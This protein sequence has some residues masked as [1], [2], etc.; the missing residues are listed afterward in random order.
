MNLEKI[1]KKASLSLYPTP[2]ELNSHEIDKILLWRTRYFLRKGN[3][4]IFSKIEIETTTECNRACSYCPN[5]EYKREKRLMPEELF[6]KIIFDLEVMDYVGVVAPHL[7]GEPLLDTRLPELISFTRQKLPRARIWIYSNGDYLNEEVYSRLRESG[8]NLF[9]VT[10]HEG[11]KPEKFLEWFEKSVKGERKGIVYRRLGIKANRGNASAGEY[12]KMQR[13]II[14]SNNVAVNVEG[15][16][17][18]CCNDFFGEF[19]FGDL[20]NESLSQVWCSKDYQDF[21]ID[22]RKGKFYLDIC[23]KCG[24]YV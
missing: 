8:V 20:R 7:Y 23:K 12:C 24:F 14:P 22:S 2:F 1:L 19:V 6:K 5:S 13:C 15:K 3:F 18:A 16:F 9:I 17:L 21:R 4:N 11:R 10:G